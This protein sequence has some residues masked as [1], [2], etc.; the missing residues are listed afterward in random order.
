MFSRFADTHSS[1]YFLLHRR[2]PCRFGMILAVRLFFKIFCQTYCNSA[3]NRVYYLWRLRK[4]IVCV[5]GA[6]RCRSVRDIPADFSAARSYPLFKLP[7]RSRRFVPFIAPLS[8]SDFRSEQFGRQHG[9][10]S[11]HLRLDGYAFLIPGEKFSY[12]I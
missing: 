4:A 12:I 6:E 1:S 10:Y 11:S 2:N 5:Q 8:G 9:A 7:A 3:E